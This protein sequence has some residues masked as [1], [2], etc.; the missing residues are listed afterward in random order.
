MGTERGVASLQL[1]K[2]MWVKVLRCVGGVID[3][4]KGNWML[5]SKLSNV[6]KV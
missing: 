1:A 5:S 3:W 6:S 2:L 4:E